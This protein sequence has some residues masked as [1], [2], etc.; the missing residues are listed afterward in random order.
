[1]YVGVG[2]AWCGVAKGR[3]DVLVVVTSFCRA[4]VCLSV[5][6]GDYACGDGV[7]AAPVEQREWN[8]ASFVWYWLWVGTGV[9]LCLGVFEVL[10]KEATVCLAM[11]KECSGDARVRLFFC[12]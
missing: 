3:V 9:G 7:G 12:V 4:D 10:I 11:Q 6:V 5:D 2:V 8:D 1:M